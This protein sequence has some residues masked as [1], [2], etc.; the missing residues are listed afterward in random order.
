MP[1]HSTT[2]ELPPLP[3]PSTAKR[4]A[5][6]PDATREIVQELPQ[7]WSREMDG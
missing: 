7:I 1:P 6:E 2:A 4:I 3:L 5:G